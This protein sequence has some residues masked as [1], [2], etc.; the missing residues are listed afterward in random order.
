MGQGN[1]SMLTLTIPKP[2]N[3]EAPYRLFVPGVDG[4]EIVVIVP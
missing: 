2:S 1:A 3:P 4:A